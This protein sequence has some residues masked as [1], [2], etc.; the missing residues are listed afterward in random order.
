MGFATVACCAFDV[1]DKLVD[2]KNDPSR[3]SGRFDNRLKLIW[4]QTGASLFGET[5]Y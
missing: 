4:F 5:T 1:S 3:R 2:I